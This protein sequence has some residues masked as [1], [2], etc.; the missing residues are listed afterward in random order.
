[1]RQDY[2]KKNMYTDKSAL[3]YL[4]SF[5]PPRYIKNS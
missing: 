2:K 1:M 3:I 4:Q 5:S